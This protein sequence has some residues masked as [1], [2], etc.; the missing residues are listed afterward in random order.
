M[1]IQWVNVNSTTNPKSTIPLPAQIPEPLRCLALRIRG[2]RL[3]A[4]VYGVHILSYMTGLTWYQWSYDSHVTRLV[5]L[6]VW[7]E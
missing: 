7:G 6:K 2:G 5:T 1:K 4:Q 3:H